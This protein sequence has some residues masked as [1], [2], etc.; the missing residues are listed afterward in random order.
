MKVVGV[1]YRA[2]RG[3]CSVGVPRECLDVEAVSSVDV[4][5]VQEEGRGED[6]GNRDYEG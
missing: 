3:I 1:V 6:D 5:L 2:P 4:G